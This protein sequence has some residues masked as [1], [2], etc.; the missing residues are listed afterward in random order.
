MNEWNY[1]FT[2]HFNYVSGHTH[3]QDDTSRIFPEAESVINQSESRKAPL[4]LIPVFPTC[5]AGIKQVSVSSTQ[6]S[7]YFLSD[8]RFHDSLSGMTSFQEESPVIVGIQWTTMFLFCSSGQQPWK[9]WNNLPVRLTNYF[10]ATG[11]KQINSHHLT[12]Q[13]PNAPD[14]SKVPLNGIFFWMQIMT[15]VCSVMNWSFYQFFMEN[16]VSLNAQCLYPWT[17][18]KGPIYDFTWNPHLPLVRDKNRRLINM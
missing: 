2:T 18:M 4:V 16:N 3:I 15:K 14:L 8:W 13:E 5:L 17:L 10:A 1:V 6:H 9:L 11:Y 7:N 12:E